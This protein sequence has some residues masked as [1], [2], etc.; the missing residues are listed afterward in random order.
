M[1]SLSFTE[2]WWDEPWPAIELVITDAGPLQ[3]VIEHWGWPSDRVFRDANVN[4]A[5]GLDIEAFATY[6]RRIAS[7]KAENFV[8]GVDHICHVDTETG[9]TPID[10]RFD[11]TQGQ[12][13]S[14]D[15]KDGAFRFRMVPQKAGVVVG[16]DGVF[17]ARDEKLAETIVDA[18][19]PTSV[20]FVARETLVRMAEFLER[21]LDRK[22]G[23]S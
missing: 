9:Y 2:A 3:V 14:G 10:S 8:L 7:M 4:V 21:E 18:G 6:V 5:R 12:Y 20:T 22:R 11:Y 19:G 1:T 23:R 16:L 17:I 13:A 15:K